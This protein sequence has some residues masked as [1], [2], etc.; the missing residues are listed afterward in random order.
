MKFCVLEGVLLLISETLH[1][2]LLSG[3]SNTASMLEILSHLLSLISALFGSELSASCSSSFFP[4]ESITGTRR[5]EGLVGHSP[6]GRLEN[7]VIPLH[8]PAIQPN[9]LCLSPNYTVTIPSEL[10]WPLINNQ[11]KVK[12]VQV[13][14]SHYRPGKALSVPG[15]WGSQISRQSAHEGGKVV[16]PKHRPPFPPSTRKYSWYSFLLEAE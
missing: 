2:F 3:D 10:S 13:K 16:S 1:A 11:I 12:K 4:G 14:D 9:L 6:C 15:G 5:T 8:L 7:V